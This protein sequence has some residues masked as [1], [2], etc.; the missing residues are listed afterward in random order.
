[1]LSGNTFAILL[2]TCELSSHS[3]KP[4]TVA[5]WKRFAQWLHNQGHQPADLLNRANVSILQQWQDPK[6]GAYPLQ[7]SRLNALLQRGNEL[8]IALE[9]WSRAGIWVITRS[10][11]DSEFYPRSLKQK[12]GQD[13][14]PVLFGCGNM[15]LLNSTKPRLAVVGS[16]EINR[17]E[18][19]DAEQIGQLAASKGIMVV[20][21]GAKGC[22][23]AAML[24]ALAQGGEAIGVLADGLFSAATQSKWR[25]SL[26]DNRLVLIS[27]FNPEARF[28]KYNAMQRNDYIYCLADSALVIR[29]GKT[30]G[31]FSGAEK[32]L[33]K[34]WVPLWVRPNED[35][36]TANNTLVEMGG[37]VFSDNAL[38]NLFTPE[39]THRQD[40]LFGG[41]LCQESE[42]TYPQQTLSL[43][44]Q[45]YQDFCK[46]IQTYPAL[47]LAEL[48]A[49]TELSEAQL[50]VWLD[51]AVEEG[52]V[53]FELQTQRY[54]N[55]PSPQNLVKNH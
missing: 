51:R 25:Q 18:Q 7:A 2:L 46:H 53:R 33:K 36:M 38:E 4:L 32:N 14:P 48:R 31:T 9:K 12:L 10:K 15:A 5:E 42:P 55:T 26:R 39:P 13:C 37:R 22:D 40:D 3:E 44:Q 1:M 8:A 35:P 54:V 23:E 11:E 29:S 47:S 30:G 20:S 6:K 49:V 43:D 16:R 28:N 17:V 34:Q 21:G 27:P 19:Q 24:G 41:N 50:A 45:F 52:K